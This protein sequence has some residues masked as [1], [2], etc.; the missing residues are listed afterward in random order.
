MK[1]RPQVVRPQSAQ[2]NESRAIDF[3]KTGMTIESNSCSPSRSIRYWCRDET[4]LGLQT[5]TRR[6][7][8][9]RGQVQWT[10]K[11]YYLYG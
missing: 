9:P 10:F 5:I 3:E 6:R 2:R 1:A 7:L 4:R 11:A 8:T